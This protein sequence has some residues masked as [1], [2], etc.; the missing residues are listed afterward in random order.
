LP[1]LPSGS[2]GRRDVAGS[3]SFGDG[4][5]AR[6][7]SGVGFVSPP[8]TH[9]TGLGS[10][11][12]A[13][14]ESAVGSRESGEPAAALGS[15]G[16]RARPPALS[17]Q[18]THLAI[19]FV[20]RPSQAPGSRRSDDAY[21]H[22]LRLA[23]YPSYHWVRLVVDPSRHWVRFVGEAVLSISPPSTLH[24]PL[25]WLRFARGLGGGARGLKTSRSLPSTLDPPHP[26]HC[27]E[28]RGRGHPSSSSGAV[29]GASLPRGT[30][31]PRHEGR[32]IA[33]GPTPEVSRIQEQGPSPGPARNASC[34]DRHQIQRPPRSRLIGM[35]LPCRKAW[36]RDR[37]GR[38]GPEGQGRRGFVT[39]PAGS[40][41]STPRR[42]P[43]SPGRIVSHNRMPD[44]VSPEAN[45]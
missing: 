2:F 6:S 3:G 21:S 34:A 38:G 11:G 12:D 17:F 36:G 37:G 13:D 20:R 15:F 10:F 24:S 44:S 5:R 43:G 23:L 1:R 8:T 9:H 41:G 14:R 30:R 27:E 35:A 31:L 26:T 33:G 42:G 18:T 29:A 40:G 39:E 19:G 22:W 16:E 32:R 7:A 45:A 28:H 4:C 25:G